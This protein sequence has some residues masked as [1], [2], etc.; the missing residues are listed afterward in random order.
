MTRRREAPEIGDAVL[1]MLD[2]LVARAAEGDTEAIEQLRR[3]EL[4]TPVYLGRG[5]AAAALIYSWAEL[6]KLVGTTRQGAWQRFRD[7][8]APRLW[9]TACGQVRLTGRAVEL[10]ETRCR[11]C[12]RA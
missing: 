4:A 3:V 2:G 10:H 7:V 9:F 11:D 8:P 1:R 5:V 6:A 12:E